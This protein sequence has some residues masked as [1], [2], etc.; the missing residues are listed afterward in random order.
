LDH[1]HVFDRLKNKARQG[2]A[3]LFKIRIVREV[4]FI[5]TFIKHPIN[6]FYEIKKHK[7]VAISAALILYFI[8]YVEI[9]LSQVYSGFIFNPVDV[10]TIS[11]VKLFFMTVAPIILAV[12]CNY[13]ISS[14]TEGNGRLRD[15][16]CSTICSFAPVILF[17]PVV[18]ILSNVLTLNEQFIYGASKTILWGWS[19]ILLYFMVKETQD[20]SF[21][22]NNKNIFITVITMVLFVAFG[23]LLYV[24]GSQVYNFIKDIIVEVLSNG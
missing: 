4:C 5:A 22:E 8:F 20:L 21:G 10:E 6:G 3:P 9:I 2:L 12:I 13:L 7:A 14:I 24:L 23:F 1:F 17:M 11:I 16:F 18:I 19:F 15:T